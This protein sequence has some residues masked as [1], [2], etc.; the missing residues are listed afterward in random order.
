MSVVVAMELTQ[1]ALNR[2]ELAGI[3]RVFRRAGVEIIPL[4]PTIGAL[5]LS[6]L[7]QYALAY[8]IKMGDALIAATAVLN[9]QPL[10]SGNVKDLHFIPD[11]D[12]RPFRLN[13]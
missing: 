5:A 12:L 10:M 8:N 13:Q 9:R 4:S 3:Q 1:G 6:Y 11:L 7:E 2:T